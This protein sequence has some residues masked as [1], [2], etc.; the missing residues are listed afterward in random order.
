MIS[1]TGIVFFLS[2][3]FDLTGGEADD[4]VDIESLVVE[5]LDEEDE[6]DDDDELDRLLSLLLV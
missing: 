5:L 1:I 4:I 2:L 3:E 6:D